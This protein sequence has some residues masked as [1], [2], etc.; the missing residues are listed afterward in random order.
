MFQRIEGCGLQISVGVWG[1]FVGY[2]RPLC[3]TLF[4]FH[5]ISRNGFQAE[6]VWHKGG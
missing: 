6:M 3:L 2:P 4:K 5:R 1:L